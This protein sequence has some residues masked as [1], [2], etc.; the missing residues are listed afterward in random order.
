MPDVNGFAVVE[1]L[2][3]DASTAEIPIVVLT[4][5]TMTPEDKARLNGRIS[6]VAGKS[7]FDRAA[8]LSLVRGL[9]PVG[10]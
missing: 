2:Q 10:A 9:C 4:S 7:G 8:F 5:K 1:E 6:C 3:E